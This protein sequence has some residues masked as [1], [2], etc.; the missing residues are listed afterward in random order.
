MSKRLYLAAGFALTLLAVS[1]SIGRAQ[2]GQGITVEWQNALLS[3][4]IRAFAALSGRTIVVAPD[5]GDPEVTA[6][7]NNADWQLA[8]DII[9]MTRGLVAR[10]DAAGVIRIEKE[11][12]T[13]A[14]PQNGRPRTS[15]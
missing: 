9:L 8:L 12:S 1:P 11:S 2:A 13:P 6:S 15:R 7:F 4:V 5:V 14:K 3:D 10:V